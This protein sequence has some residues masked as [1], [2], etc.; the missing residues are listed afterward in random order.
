MAENV[1]TTGTRSAAVW[2]AVGPAVIVAAVVLG[3]GSIVS[4]SKIG[5]GYG[6]A[7]VWV[8]AAATLLMVGMVALAG[9]LG[10]V[11]PGSLCDELAAR[12][13]RPAAVAVGGLLFVVVA[14]YQSSNNIA[15]L[16]AGEILFQGREAASI[17]GEVAPDRVADGPPVR[18]QVVR[19]QVWPRVRDAAVLLALN[20]LAIAFLLGLKRLYGVIEKAMVVLV[21]AMLAGFVTNL[22]YALV[23]ADDVGVPFPLGEFLRGF[24]PRLPEKAAFWPTAAGGMVN[25]PL[26]PVV[27]LVGT[28]FSVAG[29]FYQAYLVRE[30]GWTADQ[31]RRRLLDVAVGIGVLGTATL[32]IMTTAALVLRGRVP[33]DDLR[34]LGDVAG[35]LGPVFGA[36]AA[37][38]FALGIFAAAFSSFLANAL[39]GGT[40]GSDCLGAGSRIDQTGP[41]VGTVAALVV[42]MALAIAA[43]SFDVDLVSVILL[44]QALTVVAVPV[45][46]AALLY[47]TW[48]SAQGTAGTD[49]HHAVP[50]WAVVLGVLGTLVTTVLAVRTAWMVF[51][52][53]T[54]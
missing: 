3:P 38:L 43:R 10:V 20:G 23:A 37:V 33:M 39:I 21:L 45:L 8:L 31:Q 24:V 35:Q 2:Q 47:L 52:K 36:G 26:L 19:S 15:V 41:R 11:L 22:L 53:V 25:D 9:R 4:A 27:A 6:F 32:T 49:R 28:T 29:A 16:G 12:L 40:V 48:H 5:T 13:G 54:Q 42:G 17:E 44:A 50:T 51:L 30:K 1:A 34:S 7:F 46:A 18:P 14:F